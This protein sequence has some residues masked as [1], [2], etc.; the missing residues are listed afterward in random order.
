M[1]EPYRVVNQTTG[2]V[3]E[4]D[5]RQWVKAGPQQVSAASNPPMSVQLDPMGSPVEM[6]AEAPQRDVVRNPKTGEEMEF[7]GKKWVPRVGHAEGLIRS[8]AQGVSMGW[9][10]EAQAGRD[11]A[12]ARGYE[13]QGTL[14][15]VA[16]GLERANPVGMVLGMAKD[17]ILRD[18]EYLKR[19]DRERSRTTAYAE[20]N[21]GKAMTAEVAG[22]LSTALIPGAAASLVGRT[23]GQIARRV[24]GQGVVAGLVTG[25][26]TGGEDQSATLSEDLQSRG[27]NALVGGGV[28]G[29][30]G[31]PLGYAG[32]RLGRAANPLMQAEVETS[33]PAAA[34][35]NILARA[36]RRSDVAPDRL[37]TE[38]TMA[39]SRAT[40]MTLLDRIVASSP[41]EG[42]AALWKFRGAAS[43]PGPAR[44]IAQE[45]IGTR[46]V[47]MGERIAEGLRRYVASGEVQGVTSTTPGQTTSRVTQIMSGLKTAERRAYAAAEQVAQPVDIAGTLAATTQRYQGRAGEISETMAK[48]VRLFTDEQGRPI[49]WLRAFQDAKME[50]D[51][52]IERSMGQRGPTPLTRELQQFKKSLMDDAG[53]SNPFWK[54]AND[55]FADGKL[56][57]KMFELGDKAALRFNAGTREALLEWQ[58]LS[59]PKSIRHTGPFGAKL[60]KADVAQ[61]ISMRQEL[62]RHAFSRRLQDAVLSAPPGDRTRMF[63]TPAARDVLESI[64]GKKKADAFYSLIRDEQIALRTQRSMHGSQTAGATAEQAELSVNNKIRGAAD[65]LNWRKVLDWAGEKVAGRLTEAQNEQLM[66]RF[67]AIDPREQVNILNRLSRIRQARDSGT[68]AGGDAAAAAVRSILAPLL[69]D[70]TQRQPR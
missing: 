8:A 47:G 29:A 57:E 69:R 67:M 21:P 13:G 56:A 34:A 28:G 60:S 23:A 52:F 62:F 24:A 12:I 18:P 51:Q 27:I 3:L 1:S 35:D 40:P 54:E 55:L 38:I 45:T 63:R 16:A 58:K 17:L 65:V 25:A 19:L 31:L 37:A 22:G 6:L 68:A 48:A 7:D 59:D 2:E 44:G 33:T 30:V 15:A 14:G 10:D 64:V 5:G 11:T 43:M 41:R 4:H 46:D 53:R 42:E 26:G 32:A 50:L 66:R 9:A 61:I 70:D 36:M 20:A 49:T 39:P